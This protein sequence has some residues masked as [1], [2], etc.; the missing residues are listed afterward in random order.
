MARETLLTGAPS[1]AAV[2]GQQEQADRN[3]RRDFGVI[4]GR[5]DLATRLVRFMG[6]TL[7]VTFIVGLVGALVLHATIIENER[8]L[9]S[10]RAQITHIAT[11]TEAMR[12]ALAE[13]EAPARVVAEARAL[14]MTEAPSIE[15]LTAPAGSLDSRTLNIAANQLR[16]NE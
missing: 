16:D 9:D 3:Q 6:T 7:L 14:G 12:S 5:L 8:D 11:E 15:Y 10:Q 1:L 4:E 2:P 13:L